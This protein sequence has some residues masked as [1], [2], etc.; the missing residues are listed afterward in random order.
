[1]INQNK[2]SIVYKG[3]N[4][5]GDFEVEI[6]KNC[7]SLSL[8]D[9]YGSVNVSLDIEDLIEIH[10]GLTRAIKLGIKAERKYLESFITNP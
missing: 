2:C 10:K 1:M 9:D 3:S 4:Y 8:S 7:K 5:E 6:Q